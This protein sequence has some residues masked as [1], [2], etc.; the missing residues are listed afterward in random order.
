MYNSLG[1]LYTKD[2]QERILR[3]HILNFSAFEIE[4]WELKKENRDSASI[5]LNVKLILLNFLQDYGNKKAFS[6]SSIYLPELEIPEKR[7]LPVRIN[8]PYVLNDTLQYNLSRASECSGLPNNVIIQSAYGSYSRTIKKLENQIEIC[9]SIIIYAGNYSLKEYPEFY[10]FIQN[11][12]NN[13]RKKILIP[14]N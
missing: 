6:I 5:E 2:Q 3:E 7:T 12:K 1:N 13:D 4:H 11:I 14:K 9:R 8:T 10:S